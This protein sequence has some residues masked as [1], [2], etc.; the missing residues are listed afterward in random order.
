[1][2]TPTKLPSQQTRAH[3]PSQVPQRAVQNFAPSASSSTRRETVFA[4][5]RTRTLESEMAGHF[6]R[7][8]GLWSFLVARAARRRNGVAKR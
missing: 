8:S 2:R 3:E 1:M 5:Q 4:K 7:R 6:I